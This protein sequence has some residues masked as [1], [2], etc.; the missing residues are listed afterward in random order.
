MDELTELQDSTV[1]R[2]TEGN[3][4]PFYTDKNLIQGIVIEMNAELTIVE[5]TGYTILDVLSDVGGLQGILIS[6]I[7]L[8]LSILNYGHLDNYMV[9]KLYKQE[10]N[11]SLTVL[12]MTARIKEF[13]IERLLP[14]KLVCCNRERN[15]LAMDKARASL[16]KEADIL[17][18]VRTQ[19]FVLLALEQLLTPARLKELKARSMFKKVVMVEQT[20]QIKGGGEEKLDLSDI[21]NALSALPAADDQLSVEEVHKNASFDGQVRYGQYYES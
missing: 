2:L 12:P 21:S 13:F 15:R 18:I 7:S 20:K 5:R 19:R 9:T 10:S 16:D 8:L 6:G 17:G 14:S 1:F 11:A 4:V 3:S